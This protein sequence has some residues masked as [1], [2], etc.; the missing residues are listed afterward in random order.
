MRIFVAGAT[1]VIGRR[2]AVLLVEAGHEVTGTTRSSKKA[3][4]LRTLGVE[5]VVCDVLD[6]RALREAVVAVRPEVVVHELTDLPKAINPRKMEEQLAA[7]D[8]LRREG[9][10]NLV[11]AA[12][13]AGAQRMVAQS[14]A[15]VYA[16]RGGAVQAEEGPL[17]LDAPWPWRRTV[18]AARELERLVT[19]TNGIEGVVLRYGNL[20]GP[21]TAY[22]PDGAIAELV[23][24]RHLPIGG[25]GEGIFSFVHVDD[26]VRATVL[27]LEQGVPGI[28]NIVD[29]EPAPMRQWLP[30]YAKAL[31][32][33]PPW[34][35]PKLLLRLLAGRYAVHLATE[36]RG[37]SNAKAKRELGWEPQYPSWQNGFAHVVEGKMEVG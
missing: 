28:Y 18:E 36:A 33:K 22:A 9:T 12:L 11:E 21:G 1:G 23:R 14:I 34:R 20:Y 32:A 10:R 30:A 3:E 25:D 7:N 17:Y 26:A 4:D 27:A 6:R 31:G 24:K 16:P 29:D 19:E 8:R 5:P 13:S 15:F 35:V 37:A 2:L